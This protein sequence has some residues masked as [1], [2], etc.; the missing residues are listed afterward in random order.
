MWDKILNLAISNGIWAVLFMGLLIFQLKDSRK[1]ESKYQDTIANLNKSLGVV[2]SI[3]E[4]VDEIKDDVKELTKSMKPKV[5]KMKEK[6][7]VEVY[8]EA[9]NF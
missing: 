6:P 4:D 8:N 5:T 3:K 9:T 7:V 1:R 2:N